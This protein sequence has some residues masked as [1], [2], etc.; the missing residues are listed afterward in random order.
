MSLEENKTIALRYPEEVYN[1][2]KLAV[3]DEIIDENIK[4]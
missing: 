3:L 2:G 1:Q 4:W